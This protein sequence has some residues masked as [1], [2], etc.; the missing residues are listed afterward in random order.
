M[1]G[2]SVLLG[3][4]WGA[5]SEVAAGGAACVGIAAGA[6]GDLGAGEAAT[7]DL[8]AEEGEAIGKLN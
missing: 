7:G 2:D 4:A 8:D 1:I 5:G 3:S 6:T